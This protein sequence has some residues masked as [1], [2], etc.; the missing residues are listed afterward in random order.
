MR[1]ILKLRFL[2]H[3]RE[4]FRIWGSSGVHFICRPIVPVSRKNVIGNIS[5]IKHIMPLLISV[6]NPTNSGSAVPFRGS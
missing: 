4:K 3:K 5:I 2:S 6:C 1:P